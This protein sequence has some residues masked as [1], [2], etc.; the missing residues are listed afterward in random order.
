MAVSEYPTVDG[1]HSMQIYMNAMRECYLTL[2]Q[3]FAQRYA[4]SDLCLADF[5]YFAFHTPF[6]KMV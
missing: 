1:H 3:K 2:R 6:S 4:I 5:S